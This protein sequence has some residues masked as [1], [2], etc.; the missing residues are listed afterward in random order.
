MR[1][2]PSPLTMLW[3]QCRTLIPNRLFFEPSSQV[4]K[5][6]PLLRP[7]VFEPFIPKSFYTFYSFLDAN[8]YESIIQ[9][10]SS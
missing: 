4:L 3:N 1:C 8:V 7:K 5:Q 2:S 6:R 10:I 9:N